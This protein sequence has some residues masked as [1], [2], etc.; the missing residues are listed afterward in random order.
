MYRRLNNRLREVALMVT[1][2][3]RVVDVGTDHAILP[4]FLAVQTDC[5]ILATEI[6]DGPLA[7]ARSAVFFQELQDRIQLRKCD[8]LAGVTPEEADEVIIAGLGGDVIIGILQA[9]PWLRQQGKAMILQPMTRTHK[10][11][12]YLIS[13]QFEIEREEAVWD[14]GRLYTV[15]RAV[16]TG[17]PRAYP[18]H[19]E[20]VGEI[21]RSSRPAAADYLTRQA[22]RLE[23]MAEGME[24]GRE[25]PIEI[26]DL[27]RRAAAIRSLRADGSKDSDNTLER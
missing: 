22:A 6:N 25:D 21:P 15:L 2:G 17:V 16:Y 19:Y 7:K 9:A 3:A 11:R 26:A 18:D 23:R 10:V 20:Y 5:R 24:Q 12:R 4:I 27:R 13:H 1:D 14:A 8:G